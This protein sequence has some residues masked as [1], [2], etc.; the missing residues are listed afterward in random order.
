MQSHRVYPAF[1][2]IFSL[3]FI[4]SLVGV[5]PVQAGSLTAS[6]QNPASSDAAPT[7]PPPPGTRLSYNSTSGRLNFVGGDASAPLASAGDLS[8]MGVRSAAD[9]VLAQYA[10]QFGV[11]N[12]AKDLRLARTSQDENGRVL[13]YQQQYQGI[14]IVGGE[15]VVN[16]DT[17]G[18]VISL[19]GEVSP[20][21]DLPTTTSAISASQAL[22]AALAGAKSWYG[23]DS[24]QI[25]ASQPALWIYDLRILNEDSDAPVSLV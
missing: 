7:P 3:I 13:R 5:P 25:V 15:L 16:S 20:D 24:A 4:F 11:V 2:L 14:P 12:P 6:L 18:Q 17:Q 22:N 9:G 10:P 19:N 21:L 23:L 8:A 1:N